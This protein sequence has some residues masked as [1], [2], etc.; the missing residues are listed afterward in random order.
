MQTAH[1]RPPK[2]KPN[3]GQPLLGSTYSAS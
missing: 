1:I 3:F 2:S